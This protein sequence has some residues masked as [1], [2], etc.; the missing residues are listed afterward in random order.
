MQEKTQ[1]KSLIKQNILYFIDYKNISKYEFY[2]K[3]GITRGVL[4]QNT[5]ISEENITRFLAYFSEINPEWLITGK[6][7]MLKTGNID[8]DIGSVVNE[9]AATYNKNVYCKKCTEKDYKIK[10]LEDNI[11]TKDKLI[12]LLEHEIDRI[13]NPVEIDKKKSA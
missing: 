12:A 5:G 11:F 2:K 6:K 1:K 7:P 9:P 3:T 8:I 4:D 13:N 10:I